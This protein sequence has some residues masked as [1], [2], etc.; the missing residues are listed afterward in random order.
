MINGKNSVNIISFA[1]CQDP[2]ISVLM[3]GSSY[4]PSCYDVYTSHP[5]KSQRL[6]VRKIGHSPNHPSWVLPVWQLFSKLK[7]RAS[8]SFPFVTLEFL[9]YESQT[10][11]EIISITV[12]QKQKRQWRVM[13]EDFTWTPHDGTYTASPLHW[14]ELSHVATSNRKKWSL[15]VCPKGKGKCHFVNSQPV[16]AT[17]ST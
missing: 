14:R 10:V 12:N 13:K 2:W 8:M 9:V 17:G 6:G 11:L 15:T 4:H 7:F 3:K 1:I 5:L 16:S